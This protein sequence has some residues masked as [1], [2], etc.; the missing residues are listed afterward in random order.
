VAHLPKFRTLR[1][2]KNSKLI[3]L[4]KKNL[5][6]FFSGIFLLLIARRW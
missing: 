1:H 6:Y 2:E 4:K 5:V 3:C